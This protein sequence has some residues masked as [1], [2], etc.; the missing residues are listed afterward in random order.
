MVKVD[1]EFVKLIVKS[2]EKT[3]ENNGMTGEQ[4]NEHVIT[5][6]FEYLDK[7]KMNTINTEILKTAKEV[8]PEFDEDDFRKY[9]V[10]HT[11]NTDIIFNEKLKIEEKLRSIKGRIHMLEMDLGYKESKIGKVKEASLAGSIKKIKDMYEIKAGEET[12]LDEEQIQENV[13]LIQEMVN[14]YKDVEELHKVVKENEDYFMG[15]GDMYKKTLYQKS[16]EYAKY[17]EASLQEELFPYFKRRQECLTELRQ[18]QSLKNGFEECIEKV[19]DPKLEAERRG[20]KEQRE[21]F[22]KKEREEEK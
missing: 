19:Y 22:A 12:T 2:A 5:R 18:L 1:K 11:T 7:K 15:M 3:A 21:E 10:E 8:Y 4:K 17:V 9:V 16:P 14:T 20:N 6:L 13:D